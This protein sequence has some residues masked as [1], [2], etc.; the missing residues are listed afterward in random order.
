MR[1]SRCG[2]E[3]EL[4]EPS[5][6][7]PDAVVEM[8]EVQRQ[9]RVEENDDLCRV[10]M[11]DGDEVPRFFLRTVLPVQLLDVDDY[12]Q[13]GLWV[14]VE[15]KHAHR[16]WELWDSLDQDQEPPFP[17]FVANQ[18]AGYPNT[19]G[20]PVEIQLTGP[21]TRPRSSFS[22]ELEHPFVQ[23]CRA[24]VNTPRVLEWLAGRGCESREAVE[25][26][27]GRVGDRRGTP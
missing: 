20:L 16:A 8:P 23:E 12:T 15:E 1:C 27:D 24:G 10:L 17:G 22:K 9:S 21:T 6:L 13:W 4:L 7:R 18:V 3:H 19:I 11:G 14:E 5:F 2:S 26:G 25:Q